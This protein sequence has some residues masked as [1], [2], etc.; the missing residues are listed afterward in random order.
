MVEAG[1][2]GDKLVSAL[3]YSGTPT[4]AKFVRDAILSDLRPAKRQ[5][6]E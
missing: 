4:T 5:A 2:P 1:I 6:A 3:D